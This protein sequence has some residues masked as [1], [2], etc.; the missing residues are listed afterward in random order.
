MVLPLEELDL[1]TY[2]PDPNQPFQVRM[3]VLAAAF[4]ISRL[5]PFIVQVNVF[6][7]PAVTRADM[8]SAGHSHSP[9]ASFEAPIMTSAVSNG[10]GHHA[11]G[12]SSTYDA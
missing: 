6:T 4:C 9:Y 2:Q 12:D 1:Q 5:C 8:V 11:Q 10:H 3:H 7:S